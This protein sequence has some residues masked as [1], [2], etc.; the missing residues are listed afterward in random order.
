M[1][2]LTQTKVAATVIH[3]IKKDPDDFRGMLKSLAESFL[4]PQSAS[5]DEMTNGLSKI[6]SWEKQSKMGSVNLCN[7]AKISR[8]CMGRCLLRIKGELGHG[9]YGPWLEEN[10]ER[11]GFTQRTAENYTRLAKSCRTLDDLLER[12]ERESDFNQE[13]GE[14]NPEAE[15]NSDHTHSES[16]PSKMK[17]RKVDSM[18]KSFTNLQKRTRLFIQSNDEMLPGEFAQM[19]E[20]KSELDLLFAELEGRVSES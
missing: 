2:S 16:T 10:Q 15:P 17:P 20:A 7:M 3:A 11:L 12:L 1:D 5:I 13:D 8:W 14:E 4:P 19:Q 6:C 9:N 18:L